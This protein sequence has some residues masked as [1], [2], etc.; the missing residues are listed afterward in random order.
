MEAIAAASVA[1]SGAERDTS[2]FA[3]ATNCSAAWAVVMTWTVTAFVSVNKPSLTTN[4][5]E[6]APTGKTV[7]ATIPLA[8][9]SLAPASY[10]VYCKTSPSGSDEREPSRITAALVPLGEITSRGV[11]LASATGGRSQTGRGC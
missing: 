8:S 5:I 10:H 1:R 9:G 3:A 4:R 6:C 7:I 11:A 2:E